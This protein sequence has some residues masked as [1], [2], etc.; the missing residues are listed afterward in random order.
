MSLIIEQAGFLPEV[1]R[2]P[3]AR[4][5][6]LILAGVGFLAMF[7]VGAGMWSIFAPLESA[8]IAPGMVVSDSHRKTLQHLEGGI[9]EAILV[10]DGDAVQ[11]GQVLVRLENVKPRTALASVRGQ[12]WEA[13]AAEARL[14]A[15]RDGQ[16]EI[17]FPELL[18]DKAG[19]P[20]VA[21]ALAG[22][23][24]IFASRRSLDESKIAAINERINQVH[25]EVV[26][27]QAEIA[28]LGK[29]QVLLREELVGVRELVAKG[30]ER[31]PHMLQL[32]RELA[33][34]EGQRGNTQAQIAKAAQTVAESQADILTLKHDRQKE[35]AD[36]LRDVQKKLHELVEQERAAAD[37]LVR[38]EVRAPEAGTVTDLKVH[39]PGGVVQAGEALL[40]LVPQTDLLV[41]EAEVRPEDI[42]RVQPGLPAQV[43]LL[44]YKQRRTPPLE[45]EVVYVSAD[46]LVDKRTNQPYY[47]AKLRIDAEKLAALGPEVKMLPGMPAEAM[48]KTGQT[49]V[50]IYAFAPILDSF[51][52]AFREK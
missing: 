2:S 11:A 14:L 40:D 21:A 49:T 34:M 36:D 6:G 5:R 8:A 28:A 48:I 19:D 4:M 52:R 42:D 22:Q 18:L 27:H 1:S 50:A 29:R 10:R 31:K 25:E 26:G 32:D 33:E 12:L 37:V 20:A 45:A 23:R 30:L 43:R 41:V 16:R 15:E 9:I 51:H 13:Q 38:T 44:P 3:V 24:T 46:R 39:T 17:A 7:V 47:T 35:V